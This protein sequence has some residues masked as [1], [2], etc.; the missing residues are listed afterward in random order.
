MLS[1]YKS[2]IDVQIESCQKFAKQPLYGT[3]IKDEWV[4]VSFEEFA[5][6][7]DQMRGALKQLGIGAGD[8]VALISRNC[9][10]W[11]I[12]AY[13]SYGLKAKVVAM[14]ETQ[15][16]S[17][18]E[19]ILKDSDAK[20]VFVHNSIVSEVLEGLGKKLP[21]IEHIIDLTGNSQDEKSFKAL[22]AKGK[23]NP[24][25]VDDTLC[26]DDIM[27]II[28]TSGTTD[29]PKG[30]LLSHGNIISQIDAI[31]EL[32]HFNQNDKTLSFLPWA[33]IF[34]Q[35]CEVHALIG[36]GF[37]SAICDNVTKILPYLAE[38]EPTMLLAV[39]RIF[40]RVYENV[41]QKIH[42]SPA[43]V[44]AIFRRGMKVASDIRTDKSTPSIID[45]FV[46]FLAN[47]LVFQQ[48]RNRFGGK[49]N[50]AISGGAALQKEIAEFIANLGITVYEG[51]GLSET[52]P[53]VSANSPDAVKL[54]SVGKV[55]P[56]VRVV[57]DTTKGEQQDKNAGEIVVYGPNVM[58]GYHKLPEATRE[59][60]TDD[61][62]F[63]TGDIGYI[64]E[65]GFLI[66]SGRVKEQFKLQNGKYVVPTHIEGL[67]NLNP[68]ITQSLIY[69]D[70]REYTVAIL[71]VFPDE[72]L[73]YAKNEGVYKNTHEVLSA[74]E[75]KGI[76]DHPKI[77]SF[78]RSIVKEISKN[79]KQFEAPKKF[80]LTAEEWSPQSGLL[81][82]SFKLKRT[83]II[84][85]YASEIDK[86][87]G[88]TE[89]FLQKEA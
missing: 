24:C 71:N 84:A 12:V 72:L 46:Y 54:G 41:M 33:H 23:A 36:K 50:Y 74:E 26:Q 34:G 87:Y 85:H 38:I 48:I 18:W 88:H 64:D 83:Q 14:Y 22:L 28:Y 37:S 27:G 77:Q 66:I 32:F 51:Y 13:A 44:Q 39:P 2:L 89:S 17:E 3:K 55:V 49:L 7:V 6:Y 79:L 5:A 60:M 4:W 53:L 31:N 86:L 42:R 30:V 57:I 10:E 19:Y 62:G 21:R 40:N 35:T 15:H 59:V 43:I 70:N 68:Y 8:T 56:N 76:L 80:L 75:I 63:R 11:V 65:E 45:R 25:P 69:G 52:S 9:V 67:L 1:K 81:T 47:K 16:A 82:Q 73:D 58:Q 61:G 29:K 78:Y 20:A